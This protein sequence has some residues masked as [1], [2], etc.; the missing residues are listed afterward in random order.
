MSGSRLGGTLLALALAAAGTGCGAADDET[1]R[2]RATASAT[3]QALEELPDL[4][5]G[6]GG[7]GPADRVR[8]QGSSLV[9]GG[10]AIDLAPM[11]VD[12]FAVVSGGVF[13]RNG[14]ELWFTDL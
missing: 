7:V 13:F 1:V 5:V 9:V 11:H 3:P 8:A 6:T 4:A 2:P 14:T 12:E 10:R